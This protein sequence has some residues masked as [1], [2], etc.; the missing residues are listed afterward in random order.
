MYSYLP[1]AVAP[2]NLRSAAAKSYSAGFDG[3]VVDDDAVVCSAC[4]GGIW[5]RAFLGGCFIEGAGI[6]IS[7][8]TKS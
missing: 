3:V 8:E 7:I 5:K 2:N 6:C 1:V 4:S